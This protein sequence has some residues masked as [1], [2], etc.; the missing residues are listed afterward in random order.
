MMHSSV[1]AVPWR[2]VGCFSGWFISPSRTA[3]DRAQA[4]RAQEEEGV[5]VVAM[6]CY[7]DVGDSKHAAGVAAR[8][9]FAPAADTVV[10][11]A[12]KVPIAAPAAP[13]AKLEEEVADVGGGTEVPFT[14]SVSTKRQSS[15]HSSSCRT[16]Q[17]KFTATRSARSVVF[18][19]CRPR[20]TASSAGRSLI[21]SP[22]GPGRRPRVPCTSTAGFR[23][24]VPCSLRRRPLGP[25]T[26]R[27]RR[28]IMSRI[29]PRR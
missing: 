7:A 14:E 25:C 18:H 12:I 8:A 22:T 20:G 13:A 3:R 11:E 4:L 21:T 24:R 2:R 19:G 26:P 15:L 5:G 17:E 16:E 9:P 6:L 1:V 29:P 28:F 23:P 27:S 10:V